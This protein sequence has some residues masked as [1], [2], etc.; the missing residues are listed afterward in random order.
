LVDIDAM[1]ANWLI[2]EASTP[3]YFE[4]HLQKAGG[5]HAVSRHSSGTGMARCA[6]KRFTFID[7]CD[8]I[9]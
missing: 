2:I 4:R 9:E 8:Y 5:D 3:P 7:D 6:V 1:Y